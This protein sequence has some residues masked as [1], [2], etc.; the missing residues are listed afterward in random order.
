MTG[1]VHQ[2]KIESSKIWARKSLN[3]KKQKTNVDKQYFFDK[4]SDQ[5]SVSSYT[6]EEDNMLLEEKHQILSASDDENKIKK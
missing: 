4:I 5:D 2:N 1:I 6:D 3:N